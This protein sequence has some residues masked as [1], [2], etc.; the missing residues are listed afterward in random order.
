MIALEQRTL[1]LARQLER[2]AAELISTS[3]IIAA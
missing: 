2:R 1:K 3:F